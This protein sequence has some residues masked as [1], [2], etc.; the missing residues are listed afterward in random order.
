MTY[1]WRALPMVT[2]GQDLI[3]CD[4]KGPNV[5]RKGKFTLPQA[6]NGIP[7]QHK[8]QFSG[9]SHGTKHWITVL[10]EL[11][12]TLDYPH[13]HGHDSRSRLQGCISWGQSLRSLPNCRFPPR[14]F[15]QPGLDG[16]IAL[17]VSTPYPLK[18]NSN[19]RW[20]QLLRE[21]KMWISTV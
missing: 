7:T 4:A 9:Q 20:I 11:T 18:E 6:L 1:C 17:S 5:R 13:P 2:A 14:H 16:C 12:R 15:G 21:D 3:Q 19:K 10:H 8:K